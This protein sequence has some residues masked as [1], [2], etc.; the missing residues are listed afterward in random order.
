VAEDLSP[1]FMKIAHVADGYIVHNV[2]GVRTQIVQRLD[3]KGYD[4][5]KSEL[6][7]D[8]PMSLILT[9]N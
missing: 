5:R 1:S 9:I 4:I 8:C 3:G 7:M 2:T 6:F